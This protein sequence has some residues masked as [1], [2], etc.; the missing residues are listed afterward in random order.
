VGFHAQEFV[1]VFTNDL[2][3]SENEFY[4]LQFVK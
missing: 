1:D 4:Y 3:C 2:S